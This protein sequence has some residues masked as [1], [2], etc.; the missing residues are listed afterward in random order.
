M[1][2]IRIMASTLVLFAACGSAAAKLPPLSDEAQASAAAA[3]DKA[4]WSAKVAAYK[5]CL[6][7]NRTV[8]H[9]IQ[10]RNPAGKPSADMPACTDPGAY[11]AAQAASAVGVADSKPVPAAGKA[12]TPPAQK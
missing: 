12:A 3:K 7:Q 10:T 9:Y 8:S 1:N 6:A 2:K 4:A 5:L 11:V